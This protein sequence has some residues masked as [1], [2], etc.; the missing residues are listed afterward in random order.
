MS[1][2]L[3]SARSRRAGSGTC[4]RAAARIEAR[5]AASE[6]LMISSARSSMSSRPCCSQRASRRCA[7]T[8]PDATWACRSPAMW[9]GWR[10]LER[11]NFHTSALR[12]PGALQLADGDPEPLLEHV[13]ATGADAVAADVGVVDRRAEEGDDPLALEHRDEHG[14]VEELAGRLVRVVGDQHVAGHQ[15]VGRVLARGCRRRAM[16]S[17]LMWPGVPVTAWATMRARRSNTALARSPASRTIGLKAA[18]CSALAC[19]LTVAI[20]LCQQHLELDRDRTRRR[21]TTL[22]RSAA[23]APRGSTTSE[24]SSPTSDG[25]AGPDHRGRLALLDDRRAVEAGARRRGSSRR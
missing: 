15:R 20:R 6:R 11:M 13:P 3:P 18:R 5:V 9:S 7:P 1:M 10:T 4:R 2:R 22:D 17:E 8:S 12:S 21:S 14:D 23:L 24:P 25:P 16:A 19:S